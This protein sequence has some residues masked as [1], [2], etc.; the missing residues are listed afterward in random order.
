MKNPKPINHQQI[1]YLKN[2]KLTEL[3]ENKKKVKSFFKIAIITFLLIVI[4]SLGIGI[5]T[6]K[7]NQ[8][9]SELQQLYTKPWLSE[10]YY[11]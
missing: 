4:A 10:R 1:F 2:K 9:L 11:G 7:D 3:V 5:S 8:V 6:N